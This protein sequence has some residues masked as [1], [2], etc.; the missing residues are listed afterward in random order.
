MKARLIA[1]VV[2]CL[3]AGCYAA[4][5]EIPVNLVS[6][7]GIGKN[8]GKIKI[9]ETKYGLL[10]TPMLS[11]LSPGVHGF[12]IHSKGNC[13]PGMKDGKLVAAL[14][15]GGHF[16]PD[17]TGKH[18]GPWSPDGHLGD[19]PAI[20]VTEDGKA[21]YPVLAPRLSSIK[22]IQ[23]LALMLHEGGDNYADQPAALGGGGVRAACGVIK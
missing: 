6:E 17:K 4:T 11:S 7:S 18:M 19:L 20:Y 8:I 2:A 16:D 22:Q 15:A 23:G 9:E 13:A 5:T 21:T 14:S 12:H 1:L 10:F 3:S